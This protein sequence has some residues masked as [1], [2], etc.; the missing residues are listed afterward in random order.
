MELI[1][2]D[3]RDD[4]VAGAVLELQRW[5][6]RIEADLIGS[7]AIPPLRET[8]EDLQRCGEQFLGAFA[9]GRLVGAVSW[10]LDRETIDLHRLVVDPEWFRQGVGTG[11]VRGAL[12]ANPDARRAVVETGALN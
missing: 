2:L 12:A 11:L 10:K 7:D 4:E 6:Y 3:I 9:D 1:P 8:L 5:A